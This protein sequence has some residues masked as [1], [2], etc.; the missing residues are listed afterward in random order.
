VTP[1][2]LSARVRALKPSETLAL[3][4]RARELR[5]RGESVVS[6][7][8]GEPDFDTP[9]HIQEAGIEAIRSGHHHYTPV[10]G[11]PELRAA[12]AEKLTRDTG[13]AYRPQEIVVGS[14]AKHT[15]WNA[16]FALLEPGDEVLCPVPYWVSFPEMARLA[17]GV[18]VPVEP[19]PGRY[20]IGP[21]ELERALT[22][23]SRILILNSPNNPSGAVYSRAELEALAE[24]VRR[25]DLLV[26]SDEIYELLVYGETRH[27]SFVS[28]HPEHRDRTLLV[29]GVSKTWAMT[30]WRIGYVAA[31]AHVAE[32]ID[33]FQGQTTSNAC[34]IAQQA[35][36]RALTGDL[37]PALAMRER[38]ALRRDL[39]LARFA[40]I[41]GV[42]VLPPEGAFYV[43]PDLSERIRAS[44]L[45][46]VIDSA[47]LCNY[48]IDEAKAVCVPGAAF[49]MEHHLRLSYA[50]SEEDIVR[51]M[52]GIERALARL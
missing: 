27:V 44:R 23:R 32:G 21:E 9:V 2:T 5:A 14:G 38:F 7:A 52:D 47:S 31:P 6:F 39:M 30:G 34:S 1:A 15:I 41:P 49:G 40:R 19:R 42:R 12:I 17:G 8:A 35:A 43:F 46:Q 50:A 37:A 45:H 20:T 28:L 10:S 11:V 22:P 25:R 36:L 48:L 33:R 29:G 51:G 26:L 24:V 4:A 16:L 18:P 3:T 13:V